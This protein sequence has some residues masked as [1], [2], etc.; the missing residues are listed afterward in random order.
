MMSIKTTLS[1]L[2]V[3]IAALLLSQQ[4]SGLRKTAPGLGRFQSD[5]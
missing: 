5:Q 2:A 3:L 1:T 4:V